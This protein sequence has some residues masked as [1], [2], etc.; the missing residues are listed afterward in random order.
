MQYCTFHLGDQ[1]FGVDVLKVQE[2][3]RGLGVTPV[4]R[5]PEAVVGLMNLRGSIVTAIDARQRMGLPPA[6]GQTSP[7]NIIT[8]TASGVVSLR[9][10]SIGDVLDAESIETE[11]VPST[12]GARE[13]QFTQGVCKLEHGLLQ[14]LDADRLANIEIT[15]ATDVSRR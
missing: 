8:R 5:A 10:D 1:L 14:I 12:A 6:P 13:R 2:V 11:A 3:I 7:I 4:P 9:V 15:A